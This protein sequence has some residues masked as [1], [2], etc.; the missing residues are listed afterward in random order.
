MLDAFSIKSEI[1]NPIPNCRII[2]VMPGSDLTQ[3]TLVKFMARYYTVGKKLLRQER[4]DIFHQMFPFGWEVGFN[5]LVLRGY[6][7]S[8]PFVLKFQF[9]RFFLVHRFHSEDHIF[10][11]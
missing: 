4:F 1:E 5:P 7:G 11:R 10:L 8:L 6:T 9:Q 2:E 3:M